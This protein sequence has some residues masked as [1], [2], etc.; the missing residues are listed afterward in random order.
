MQRP[1]RYEGVLHTPEDGVQRSFVEGSLEAAEE[2]AADILSTR[3]KG[4]YVEIFDDW[5]L[6]DRVGPV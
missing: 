6:V 3:E 4:S 1:R 2:R 5:G